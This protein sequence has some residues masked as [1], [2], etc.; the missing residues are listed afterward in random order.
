MVTL[1]KEEIF[2]RRACL[3][4]RARLQGNE[5]AKPFRCLRKEVPGRRKQPV[6]RP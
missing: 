1:N 3:Q 6:Q 4:V 5:A 2:V